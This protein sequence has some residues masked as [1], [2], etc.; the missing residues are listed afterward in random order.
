MGG[1]YILLVRPERNQREVAVIDDV[2]NLEVLK[3]VAN[4][5]WS[6]NGIGSKDE[7]LVAFY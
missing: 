2:T 6:W 7:R 4:L 1:G 3:T 5:L